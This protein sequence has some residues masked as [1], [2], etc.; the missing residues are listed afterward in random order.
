[1][2]TLSNLPVE[3]FQSHIFPFLILDPD[4]DLRKFL[5]YAL[6]EYKWYMMIY[7]I[8]FINILVSL[9]NISLPDSFYRCKISQEHYRMRKLVDKIYNHTITLSADVIPI[10]NE[11]FDLVE[12]NSYKISGNI[13]KII[14]LADSSESLLIRHKDI[15]VLNRIPCIGNNITL[16]ISLPRDEGGY[17]GLDIDSNCLGCSG[18]F[19]S[20]QPKEFS[21]KIVGKCQIRELIL[22][23]H[24]QSQPIFNLVPLDNPLLLPNPIHWVALNNNL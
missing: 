21:F 6:V 11:A 12:S 4:F 17:W 2:T 9:L 20:K 16:N 10:E 15:D 14:L 22:R 13:E 24:I 8:D 18:E 1:M 19:L 7:S 23:T 5:N 3:I